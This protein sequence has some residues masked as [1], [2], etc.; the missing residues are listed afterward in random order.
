MKKKRKPGVPKQ[1]EGMIL[2]VRGRKVMLDADLA[3]LYGVST[4]A[5][6]QAVRRNRKRFPKDFMFEL[7]WQESSRVL[8]AKEQAAI[9]DPQEETILRSQTV[10]LRRGARDISRS[11]I[12]T[13]RRGAIENPRSQIVTLESG[14]NVKYR[15]FAF[16]EQGVA[17]LSSVLRGTRAARMNVEIMR[18]FVR[19]RSLLSAH[20]DLAQKVAELEEKYDGQFTAVFQALHELLDPPP[21]PPRGRIGFRRS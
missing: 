9:L 2:L 1:I 17:M 12:V 18:A 3:A 7:T 14:R 8:L 21:D 10:T 13:L 15:P 11:Q 6:K 5:L 19:L 4:K 16:T 20:A